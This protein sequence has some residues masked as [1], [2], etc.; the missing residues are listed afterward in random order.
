MTKSHQN[1]CSLI[2]LPTNALKEVTSSLDERDLWNLCRAIPRVRPLLN[3][4]SC[5]LKLLPADAVTEV[6]SGLDAKDLFNLCMSNMW[7]EKC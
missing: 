6:I 5:F 3:G 1:T 7:L 2:L 4:K